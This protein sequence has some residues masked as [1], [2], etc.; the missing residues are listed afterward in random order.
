MR[1]CFKIIIIIIFSFASLAWFY[2]NYI[3]QT[4]AKLKN[5]TLKHELNTIQ[6]ENSIFLK[7]WIIMS[8]KSRLHRT[9]INCDCLKCVWVYYFSPFRFRLW[10]TILKVA[11]D[12]FS[13]SKSI[14]PVIPNRI[15]I[16]LRY[17]TLNDFQLQHGWRI[18]S[19]YYF[20]LQTKN[21]T[22]FL[23]FIRSNGKNPFALRIIY[24]FQKR[25]SISKKLPLVM[26]LYIFVSLEMTIISHRFKS[27]WI[28]F[29]S[30]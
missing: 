3:C 5:K 9:T 26:E 29:A 28:F 2:Y 27:K 21:N 23:H 30:P 22:S 12:V 1:F 14:V 24:N 13:D 6:R 10:K 11:I 4:S 25:R 17:Y 8:N 19:L 15:I 16:V 20:C 7:N 18:P